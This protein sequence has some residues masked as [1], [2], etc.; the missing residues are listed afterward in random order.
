M[1]RMH[2]KVIVCCMCGRGYWQGIIMGEDKL[3]YDDTV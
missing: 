1:E 3:S 2:M